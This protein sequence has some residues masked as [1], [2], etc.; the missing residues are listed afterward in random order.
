MMHLAGV[1]FFLLLSFLVPPLCY[2]ADIAL[3]DNALDGSPLIPLISSA[4]ETLDIEIYQ[5]E[6]PGV[7]LALLTAAKRGVQVRILIEPTPVGTRCDIFSNAT[8]THD[9]PI[10]IYADACTALKTFKIQLENLGGDFKPFNKALCGNGSGSDEREAVEV[11]AGCFQ[12]GKAL[13]SDGSVALLS[14]G[15][16]NSTNLCDSD[17]NPKRCNRDF[18][19]SIRTTVIVNNLQTI[20]DLD[21]IGVPY[22]IPNSLPRDALATLT[23]SPFSMAPL[24]AFLQSAMKSVEIEEQYLN[25]PTVNSALIETALRGVDVKILVS[26][27]CAFGKPSPSVIERANTNNTAFESA[28]AKVMTFPSSIKINGKPGYL[29]AKAIVVDGSR[30]WVGSVNGSTQ[31]MT[32]NREYGIFINDPTVA[33]K[34]RASFL[35]DFTNSNAETWQDSLN[36]LNDIILPE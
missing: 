2:A 15:N 17:A 29:H 31:S 7:Q 36:C 20:F 30:A 25:D 8:T 18:T 32:R 27:Y 22:S 35:G 19:V 34:L 26:S 5:M 11:T 10:Y 1:R 23:V 3:H 6:N 24:T 14:T 13:I 33:K 16:F 21:W 28:G 12:H 9:D 4:R